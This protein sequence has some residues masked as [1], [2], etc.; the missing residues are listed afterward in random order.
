MCLGWQIDV[1]VHTNYFSGING[2]KHNSSG[3]SQCYRYQNTDIQKPNVPHAP[4]VYRVGSII[5]QKLL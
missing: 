4:K 3:N 2:I 5:S 1:L